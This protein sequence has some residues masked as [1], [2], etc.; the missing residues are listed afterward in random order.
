VG[1]QGP[2]KFEGVSLGDND[3][4][5]D[6]DE[7]AQIFNRGQVEAWQAAGELA[8]VREDKENG[9]FAVL[10]MFKHRGQLL[11][12]GGSKTQ[13]VIVSPDCIDAIIADAKSRPLLSQIFAE[14]KQQWEA[15]SALA[16][17]RAGAT[18][19]G[20]LCDGLHFVPLETER[21][22]VK[23][24][25]LFERGLALSPVASLELLYSL[26]LPAVSYSLLDPTTDL[27]L[28]IQAARCG[29]GEGY[30]MY[31]TN[32]RTG[33]VVLAK[34]KTAVY[35]VK[36]MTREMLRS[37]G[38]VRLGG[39]YCFFGQSLTFFH[40]DVFVALQLQRC[41]RARVCVCVCVCVYFRNPT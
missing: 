40:I 32:T 9:K 7:D 39:D 29:T 30:V 23:W 10:K 18:V 41:A 21:P 34:N 38:W 12:V 5:P 19:V 35:I 16:D 11:A 27:N 13:H 37:F 28:T 8:I 24:F 6:T 25:G 26:G 20:E 1:L 15:L 3:D 33:E 36:R 14:V 17:V 2:R 31:F 4:V 22:Q